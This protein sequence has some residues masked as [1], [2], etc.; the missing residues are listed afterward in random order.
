MVCIVM[1]VK[2]GGGVEVCCGEASAHICVCICTHVCIHD[3]V[4]VRVSVCAR[5]R[6]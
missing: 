5:A 3:S 1:V 4:C 6:A 2:C